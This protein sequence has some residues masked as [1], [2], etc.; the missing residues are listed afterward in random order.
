MN[1]S[2]DRTNTAQPFSNLDM[3]RD[4]V[5]DNIN[6]TIEGTV[7]A[8]LTDEIIRYFID[9]ISAYY[10]NLTYNL[11][12]PASNPPMVDESDLTCANNAVYKTLFPPVEQAKI[13][14]LGNNLQ[15]IAVAYEVARAVSVK[16]N[17]NSL[18][19]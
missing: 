18:G 10:V 11:L 19:L 15:Q 5:L 1:F 16:P 6:N 2:V 7:D 4:E 13:A 3:I 12:D 9:G 8:N 14:S 17:K